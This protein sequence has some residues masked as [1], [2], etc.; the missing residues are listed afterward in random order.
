[1]CSLKTFSR[2]FCILENVKHLLSAD[3]KP[4]YN[5]GLDPSG[6]VHACQIQVKPDEMTHLG[7]EFEKRGFYLLWT[8][9]T[10]QMA[11]LHV[12]F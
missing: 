4:S 2:Y 6:S 7:Q 5:V 9:A 11:G 8:V 10:G 3:K 1:M 12:L